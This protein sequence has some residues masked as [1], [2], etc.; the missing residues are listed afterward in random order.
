MNR[1]E[2]SQ[3]IAHKTKLPREIV[4]IVLNSAIAEIRNSLS[5]GEEVSLSGLGKFVAEY[6]KS[7][8]KHLFSQSIVVTTKPHFVPKFYSFSAL[9]RALAADFSDF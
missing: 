9:K 1:T 3:L 8:T 6:R 7:T 2:F 5:R 4:D